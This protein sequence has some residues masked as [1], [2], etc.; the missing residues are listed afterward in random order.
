MNNEQPPSWKHNSATPRWRM[1]WG[2]FALKNLNIER[3]NRLNTLE[4]TFLITVSEYYINFLA[5]F[6]VREDYKG[7]FMAELDP[8]I[9]DEA[10]LPSGAFWLQCFQATIP[11]SSTSEDRK[12]IPPSVVS[13]S[14]TAACPSTSFLLPWILPN[15][16]SET[17]N[18]PLPEQ[19]TNQA[20]KWSPQLV[21]HD[22][23]VVVD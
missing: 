21:V 7:G 13:W 9:G 18:P 23:L 15:L 6:W 10:S 5:P 8:S 3:Q 14:P 2:S 22:T 16:H 1:H 20:R 19:S 4:K 17:E 12:Q 11:P